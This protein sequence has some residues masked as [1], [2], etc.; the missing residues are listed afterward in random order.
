MRFF[1]FS[2]F[3]NFQTVEHVFFTQRPCLRPI[4]L[5]CIQCT[6]QTFKLVACL[7]LALNNEIN[8]Y[9]AIRCYIW[10][11]FE[12]L[13]YY[14]DLLL[15]YLEHLAVILYNLYARLH[16]MYYN[17]RRTIRYY[18]AI[19]I[20]KIRL[21]AGRAYF[22]PII[23]FLRICERQAFLE[24]KCQCLYHKVKYCVT[25]LLHYVSHSVLILSRLSIILEKLSIFPLVAICGLIDNVAEA[26]HESLPDPD[27][28]RCQS[29]NCQQPQPQHQQNSGKPT[30]SASFRWVLSRLLAT[31]LNPRAPPFVPSA[32]MRR[33]KWMYVEE[34][35]T[36][37]L[38]LPVKNYVH[39]HKTRKNL[40]P[41]IKSPGAAALREESVAP[42]PR[43][44]FNEPPQLPVSSPSPRV[45]PSCLTRIPPAPRTRLRLPRGRHRRHRRHHKHVLRG[46]PTPALMRFATQ[47]ES[48]P[49]PRHEG[50]YHDLEDHG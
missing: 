17:S 34:P 31:R 36:K 9:P 6:V 25:C 13:S 16:N 19:S 33:G 24:Y 4:S 8:Y 35:A 49:L 38:R 1:S 23:F 46:L 45:K 48:P 29:C 47:R 43:P 18:V 37:Q 40:P 44:R 14:H 5:D 21:Y 26:V 28:Q 50:L 39:H 15:Y 7:L 12:D 27:I 30:G 41:L 11:R 20:N 3:F 10:E 2:K 22:W 32:R 42:A